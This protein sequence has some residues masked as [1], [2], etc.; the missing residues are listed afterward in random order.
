ML[1][2]SAAYN[3]CNPNFVIQNID[4]P[5][6][7]NDSIFA[8]L[9]NVLMRGCPTLPS[10]LLRENFG[11]PQYTPDISYYIDYDNTDWNAIIKGGNESNPALY[12]CHGAVSAAGGWNYPDSGA[13]K[14][15]LQTAHY[16]HG[17]F[18]P[19]SCHRL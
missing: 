15:F 9:K 3:N 5:T 4:E 18:F 1:R 17:Y 8:I 13:S 7:W 16:G 12:H 19:R 2:V 6:E 14:Q 10:L 11:L